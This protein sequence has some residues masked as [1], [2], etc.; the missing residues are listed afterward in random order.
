MQQCQHKVR[1]QRLTSQDSC[2]TQTS[3][4]FGNV[5]EFTAQW[6][7]FI[8]VSVPFYYVKILPTYLPT[9]PHTH[10]HLSIYGS[11]VLLLDL[12]RFFSFFTL[13]IFGRTPW[14]GDQTLV[15]LVPTQRPKQIQNK[16]TQTSMLQVGFEPRI[17]EFEWRKRVHALNRAA[18]VSCKIHATV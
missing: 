3:K 11:T 9:H 5:V 17:L 8:F 18:T 15:R 6:E 12:G 2:L 4:R 13:Y 16:R 10:T 14:K 7:K 1:E